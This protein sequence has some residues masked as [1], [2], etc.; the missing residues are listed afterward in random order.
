MSPLEAVSGLAVRYLNQ[1][2]LLALRSAYFNSRTKLH[3]VMRAIYGTF[4]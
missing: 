1:K 4:T 2:R 3:P